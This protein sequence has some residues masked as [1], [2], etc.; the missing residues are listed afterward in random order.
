MAESVEPLSEDK[1]LAQR[2]RSG[3]AGA[4][5]EL[6]RRFQTGLLAVARARGAGDLAPDLVQDALAVAITNLRRG[7]WRGEGALAA[8]L[9]G[10]LRR[11]HLRMR[12][13]SPP[14]PADFLGAQPS[15]GTDPLAAAE[16]AEARQRIREALARLPPRHREVLLRHYFDE[17]GVA[18]IAQD[19]GIPRGTVLSR[20]HHARRKLRRIM[21]QLGPRRD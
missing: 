1:D 12:S 14:L 8:Y 19:L 4:E 13:P 2:I 9:A 20:L 21:N 17:K 7:D 15:S 11:M 6:A 10:I 3:E 16:R 5:D 18:E